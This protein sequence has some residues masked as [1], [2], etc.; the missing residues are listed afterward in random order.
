MIGCEKLGTEAD[1]KSQT[2]AIGERN[3][4]MSSFDSACG[5]PKVA[6]EVATLSDSNG[7]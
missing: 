7:R 3:T 5:Y 6:I 1:C 4:V 2:A